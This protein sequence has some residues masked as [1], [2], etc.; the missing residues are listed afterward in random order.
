MVLLIH[1]GT[2]VR[3]ILETVGTA[4]YV[5]V[6]GNISATLINYGI[7]QTGGYVGFGNVALLSL[8]I[9][10]TASSTGGHL[11]PLVTFSAIFCGILPVSKGRE[12]MKSD[13]SHVWATGLT[14]LGVTGI[15]YL[16]GQALG[17]ALAGGVL[18][19]VYR[20]RSIA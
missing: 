2:R 10:A 14:A 7:T 6:S 15:L 11:N 9:Y 17:G 3:Q 1:F 5:Y 13:P 20:D 18:S 16:L 12:R 4:F 8:F 19:G